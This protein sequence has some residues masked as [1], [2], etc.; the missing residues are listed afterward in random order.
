MG[1]AAVVLPLGSGEQGCVGGQA[2][3]HGSS[4]GHWASPRCIRQARFYP[5]VNKTL[6]PLPHW[7][8]EGG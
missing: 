4:T 2:G 8:D 5:P 7:A 6:R 3:G 1:E